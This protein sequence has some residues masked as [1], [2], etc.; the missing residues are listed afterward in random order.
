MND[1]ISTLNTAY[2]LQMNNK[3]SNA[4]PLLVT[5]ASVRYANELQNAAVIRGKSEKMA[6]SEFE[7]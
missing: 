5:S 6:P 3:D 2:S 4:L 7:V 1:H